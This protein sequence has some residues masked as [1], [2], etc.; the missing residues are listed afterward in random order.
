[1]SIELNSVV[2]FPVAWLPDVYVNP[3][4]NGNLQSSKYKSIE[5]AVKRTNKEFIIAL[6][7]AI[8]VSDEKRN[9]KSK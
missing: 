1:M 6:N 2:V 3:S 9:S 8:V 4:N 7:E 5:K